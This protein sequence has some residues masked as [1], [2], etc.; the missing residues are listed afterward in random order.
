MPSQLSLLRS[1]PL[2]SISN[3]WTAAGLLLLIAM[4]SVVV[5]AINIGLKSA[6]VLNGMLLK[7]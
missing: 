1:R 6:S 4:A 7:Q 3:W 2:F 5:I